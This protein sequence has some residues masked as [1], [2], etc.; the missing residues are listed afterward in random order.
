MID[1]QL[2]Q[3]VLLVLAV[4]IGLSVAYSAAMMMVPSVAKPARP[5]RPPRGG[6]RRDLPRQPQPEPEPQPRLQLDAEED[7]ERER[8]LVLV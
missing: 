8:E 1:M 7:R 2:F 6:Q 4:L 3:G 5:T